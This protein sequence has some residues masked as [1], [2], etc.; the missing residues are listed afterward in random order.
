MRFFARQF[1]KDNRGV[2][3][4]ETLIALPVLVLISILF[5]EFGNVM[6]QRQQL[7]A[8]VKD[9]ARYWS[10]CRPVTAGGATFMNC[11]ENTARL[12]A[13]TGS[14]TGGTTRVPGW[15]DASELTILPTTPPT[16][17]TPTDIVTVQGEVVYN[18][19]MLGN[20]LGITL[21]YYHQTRYQGW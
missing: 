2:V 16:S 10:R 6:W 18:S 19:F 8:G 7:Q 1:I 14:P 3:L 13:F 12:I 4:I 15:D 17:P 21:S 5:V 20:G 11:S 9:A